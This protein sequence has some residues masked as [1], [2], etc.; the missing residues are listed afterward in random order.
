MEKLRD[1]LEAMKNGWYGHLEDITEELEEI[2]IDPECCY[3]C[4]EY[5]SFTTEIEEENVEVLIRLGGT[6]RTITVDSFELD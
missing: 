3:I 4:R 5:I 1:K 6:E 2:G